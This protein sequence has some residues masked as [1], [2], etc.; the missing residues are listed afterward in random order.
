MIAC[1]VSKTK[2]LNY[3]SI[4]VHPPTNLH[5]RLLEG[6]TEANI[7]LKIDSVKIRF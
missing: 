3:Q 7:D 4:S 5:S 2:R 6:F 1:S